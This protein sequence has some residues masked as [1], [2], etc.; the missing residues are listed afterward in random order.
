MTENIKSP[1]LKVFSDDTEIN[2]LISVV[3]DPDGNQ[4]ISFKLN[5]VLPRSKNVAMPSHGIVITNFQSPR[6]SGALC[7]F[8]GCFGEWNFYFV[9]PKIFFRKNQ[10]RKFHSRSYVRNH[11]SNNL[12]PAM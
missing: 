6:D 12:K 3:N 11:V 8:T 2:F 10:N 5:S 1:A 9:P 4:A 7:P